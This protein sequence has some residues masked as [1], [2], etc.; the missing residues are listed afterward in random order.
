MAK[1]TPEEIEAEKQAAAAAKKPYS[2]KEI[3]GKV[4]DF[5]S[6]SFSG[7]TSNFIKRK[8]REKRD[9]GQDN[10]GRA[11]A[12]ASAVGSSVVRG[13]SAAGSAISDAAQ[14]PVTADN[15]TGGSATSSLFGGGTPKTN[16]GNSAS[17]PR[18]DSDEEFEGV[19]AFLDDIQ[20]KR[21]AG[22]SDLM[23][24]ANQVIA[25]MKSRQLK[26]D[27]AGQS[28]AIAGGSPEK[29]SEL[30]DVADSVMAYQNAGKIKAEPLETTGAYNDAM[31][32]FNEKFPSKRVG[33]IAKEGETGDEFSDR[34]KERNAAR[35]K[36][37]KLAP[38]SVAQAPS[39]PDKGSP[40]TQSP[41]TQ[42]RDTANTMSQSD[43]LKGR[44]AFGS[45]LND[46]LDQGGGSYSFS[47]ADNKRAQELGIGR[48]E[49]GNFGRRR[50]REKRNQFGALGGLS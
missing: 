38:I 19:Q 50:E 33:L 42:V 49:L 43:R 40:S 17:D 8:E 34:L 22:P 21:S 10:T 15:I 31:A 5:F 47:E 37:Q 45:Y 41:S 35:D 2:A 44:Q 23:K 3:A 25:D 48:K 7:P 30:G 28:T 20:R 9:A 26:T 11:A 6:E 13:V 4:G 39:T 24:Q 12:T 16:S 14:G 36:V 1:K 46:K 32:A 18:A 29:V 27:L